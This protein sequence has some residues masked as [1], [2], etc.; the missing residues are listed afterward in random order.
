M[1]AVEVPEGLAE[2]P[3]GSELAAALAGVDL[4]RVPNDRI[5]QVLRAQHRQLCHEQA[6]MA[7]VIAE[8]GRCAGY[9]EPGQVARLA[10]PEPYASA[11]TRA[12]LRWTRRAADGE[13]DLAETIVH[14][15]PMV[16]A[17]W[18][19]G[20]ADRPRVRVFEH[21][22]TGLA[23][24]QVTKICQVAVPRARGLTTGQLAV[25]LRRMVLAID[26]QAAAR[27]YRQGVRERNVIAYLAPDGTVTL[28]ANGLPA[29]EAEAACV[30]LQ[31]LAA[32]AKRAGHPGLIGQIRCDLYLGMLDGR[33]H[34]MTREQIITALIAGY[35]AAGPATPPAGPSHAPDNPDSPDS[36]DNPDSPD[37]PGRDDGP[38]GGNGPGDTDEPAG[39]GRDDEPPPDDGDDGPP[40]GETAAS[41]S[42][43]APCAQASTR[44]ERV[45][46]EIRV[47]LATLL[48]RD[49]H[50]AEIPGLGLLLAPDARARVALQGRSQWRF[51]VTDTAGHLVFDGLTR[52]RPGSIARRGPRGGIVEL[53]LP[54][55]LLHEL[56]AGDTAVCGQ[57]GSLIADIAEQYAHRDSRHQLLDSHPD[58]RLPGAA[59]RRHTQIRDR[60]C[61]FIG[62]RRSATAAEQDHTHDHN[63]GGVTIRANLGPACNHDHRVKHRGGWKVSQPDPGTFIWTSPLGGIYRTRGESFLPPMP[64]PEP[65]ELEP[66]FDQ[67]RAVVEGPIL[68]RPP[69]QPPHGH[70]PPPPENPDE[71]PPF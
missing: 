40:S 62:C 47:A 7:A 60:T 17:A 29:D 37:G 8:V 49:E 70:P 35:R 25:L 63:L 22:L 5:L 12:A 18:L 31:D 69:P 24:E 65:T 21:Y 44:D 55:T 14:G 33:F 64:Q 28:S 20:D 30:R 61:T 51:A 32:A 57:W 2:M 56:A 26:P 45:G 1:Q 59:L 58:A 53:H 16:F 10:A 50:P 34:H 66:E 68:H 42:G 38:H 13:H 46:I 27:W 54:V 11:E 6:R 41:G 43:S 3:P 36:P 52:R 15:M 71:P 19:A 67:P 48:G 39:P 9:P 23:P 4:A